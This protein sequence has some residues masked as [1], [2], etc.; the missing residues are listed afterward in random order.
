VTSLEKAGLIQLGMKE[1]KLIK[2]LEAIREGIDEVRAKRV[3]ID[4]ILSS[5]S[6]TPTKL[7]AYML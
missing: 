3:V 7:S 5:S 1:F 6:N 2:L 4:P